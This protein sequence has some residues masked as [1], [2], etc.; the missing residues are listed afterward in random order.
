MFVFLFAFVFVFLFLSYTLQ[1]YLKHSVV[2]VLQKAAGERE[3]GSC[4]WH[5]RHNH[6]RVGT[7]VGKILKIQKTAP[8]DSENT[9]DKKSSL[10][11]GSNIRK[12]TQ[13]LEKYSGWFGKISVKTEKG[14]QLILLTDSEKY[15]GRFRKILREINPVQWTI[16]PLSSP[17]HKKSGSLLFL[18]YFSNMVKWI[19]DHL[20][21]IFPKRK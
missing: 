2:C 20:T 11:F 7:R 18:L 9:S 12:N 19:S 5:C 1:Q 14:L 21:S 10:N 8:D 3:V 15:S 13:D 6:A 16:S 4:V 17:C